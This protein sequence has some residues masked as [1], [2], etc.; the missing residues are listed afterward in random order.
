MSD[1]VA[2]FTVPKTSSLLRPFAFL[3][4]F[5]GVPFGAI[6]G[7]ILKSI[8]EP[9]LE[10]FWSRF[11]VHF[12]ADFGAILGAFL[13]RFWTILEPMSAYVWNNVSFIFSIAPWNSFGS[14]L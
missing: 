7:T 9:F 6:F 4:D 1:Q 12:G 3:G 5:E 13:S 14:I 11:Q 2:P 10:C 8:L